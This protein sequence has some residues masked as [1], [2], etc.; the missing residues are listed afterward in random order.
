MVNNA[1]SWFVDLTLKDSDDGDDGRS[2]QEQ[3]YSSWKSESNVKSLVF[4][5]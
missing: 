4:P 2:I 3:I 5:K 1:D